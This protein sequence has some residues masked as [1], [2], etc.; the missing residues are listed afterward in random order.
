M[1]RL[2][3]LQAMVNEKGFVKMKDSERKEYYNL[4]NQRSAE[5]FIM[6]QDLLEKS[7]KMLKN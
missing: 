3:E 7:R 4:L 6:S 5:T 1:S 2:D